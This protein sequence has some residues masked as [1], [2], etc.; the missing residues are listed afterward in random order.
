VSVNALRQRLLNGFQRGFPLCPA[1]F[2]EIA[3][4]LG[5]DERTVLALL[6]RALCDGEVS[7]V[8][9]VLRPLALGASTLA[10]MAVPAP[11]LER[12]ARLV[13]GF[14]EVNHNYER[15]HR[16]N[17]W[18]VITAP[19]A[20]RLDAVLGAIERASGVPVLSLPMLAEY[21]IDLGFDLATGA[22]APD[23]PAPRSR[24]PALTPG[25]RRLLAA[26]EPGLPLVPAPYA[27]LASRTG[28]REATVV[29]RLE[30]LLASGVVKR[31]G[32]VVRHHELGWHS[33]AMVAWDVPD[34]RV[35][36]TGARLAREPGVTL[37]YR[38]RRASPAWPNN[39]Y[40]MVH[41]RSRHEVLERV[42]VL[43]A[44][45]GLADAPREVL[46]SVRRFKQ[47]GARYFEARRES[48]DAA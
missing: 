28:E 9:A 21:H 6:E 25:D 7:R 29:A 46:F 10:A 12:V 17:L 11:R 4:A 22:R 1:P 32:V 2:A 38:R 36:A 43:T 37:C 16:I 40:V 27:A 34:G 26:L 19:D 35:D 14:R 24:T 45:C 23:L 44:R 33:N 31:I 8:G 13:S 15:E 39:L 41:G 42:G 20:A 18:F 47:R 30:R 48:S 5:T 3:G